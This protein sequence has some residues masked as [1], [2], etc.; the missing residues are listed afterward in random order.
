MQ[1][2]CAGL[3]S[4]EQR[5]KAHKQISELRKQ[6]EDEHKVKPLYAYNDG[7]IQLGVL[8]KIWQSMDEM[9]FYIARAD[10]NINVKELKQMNLIELYTHKTLLYKSLKKRPKDE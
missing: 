9:L 5:L 8:T 6:L 7:Q 2:S 4:I 1:A 10:G 3:V